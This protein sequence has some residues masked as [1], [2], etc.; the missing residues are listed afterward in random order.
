M[1]AGTAGDVWIFGYGS[2]MWNPSF[3]FEQRLSGFVKNWSRQFWQGSTD[4][5]GVP[6][7]PGRV[8]TLVP[9]E[10]SIV[11]GVCYQLSKENKDQVLEYLNFREKGGYSQ[12]E[13][14]V[15]ENDKEVPTLTKVLMYIAL[16]DNEEYLGAS[17]IKSMASQ[18]FHSVGPSGPNIEYFLKLVHTL[19][20]MGV[21]ES[22]LLELYVEVSKLDSHGK[23]SFQLLQCSSYS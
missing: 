1:E 12:L 11:W 3:P 4:H 17:C 13:V 15:W 5:R 10:D 21:T 2:L 19:H 7:S 6:G 22:H 9:A 14:D 16:P 18:I 20:E 8:V 23:H